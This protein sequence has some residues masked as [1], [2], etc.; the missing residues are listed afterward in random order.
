MN[1]YQV[2]FKNP[3]DFFKTQTNDFITSNHLIFLKE[4]ESYY[5][6]SQENY[7]DQEIMKKNK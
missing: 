1:Y 7:N 3:D 4:G 6:I 5:L 2:E